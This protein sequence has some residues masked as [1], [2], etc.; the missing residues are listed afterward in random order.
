M[1]SD[2]K[3][4]LPRGVEREYLTRHTLQECTAI[5]KSLDGT[6]VKPGSMS[7][8]RVRFGRRNRNADEA[9][10][11]RIG[12]KQRK[13]YEC[14]VEVNLKELHG[15]HFLTRLTVRNSASYNVGMFAAAAFLLFFLQVTGDFVLK[16]PENAQILLIFMVPLFIALLALF[17]IAVMRLIRSWIGIGDYDH[18]V[19]FPLDAVRDT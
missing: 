17:L 8:Y 7:R 13:G 10:I 19:T 18:Y 15:E 9:I 5:L 12:T 16:T 14:E 4:G 3:K 1:M 6:A 11:I 2:K